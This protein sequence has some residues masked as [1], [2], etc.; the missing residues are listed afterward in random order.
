MRVILSADGARATD[1]DRLDRLDA[2]VEGDRVPAPL[3][4]GISAVD[5]EHLW[6]ATDWLAEQGP[7][8]PDWRT[9]FDAMIGYAS[10]KGWVRDGSV[11]AHIAAE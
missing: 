10:R 9:K 11:R 4:A 8:D 5:T 3:P 1:T 6:I 7:V 2:L